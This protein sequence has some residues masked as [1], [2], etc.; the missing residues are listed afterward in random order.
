MRRRF[1]PAFL[2]AVV[3]TTAASPAAGLDPWIRPVAGQMSQPFRAPRTR[4]GK[5]HLGVDFAAAPGTPVHAAGPGTVA[6]AGHVAGARYVVVRHAGGLRTTYA[7]L[8]SIAVRKGEV[9]ARGA[10]VGA[11]GGRGEN[12]EPDVVHF[13]VRIGDAY[14]DP[15]RLFGIDALTTDLT[16]LVHLAPLDEQVPFATE[17]DGPRVPVEL[18]A[19]PD[20]EPE[21]ERVAVPVGGYRIAL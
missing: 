4:F 2:V 16:A 3:L 7:F 19:P 12:H 15:M 13:G 1:A 8:A 14:V 5:G 6:F 9:L 20:L 17:A 21:P 11:T 18:N 10:V